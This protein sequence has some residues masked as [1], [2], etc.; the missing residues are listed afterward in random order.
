MS[1]KFEQLKFIL[2]KQILGSQ[3]KQ[4]ITVLCSFRYR[5]RQGSKAVCPTSAVIFFVIACVSVSGATIFGGL[6]D[7]GYLDICQ[8]HG[9]PK[10]NMKINK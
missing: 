1:N 3:V 10:R 6:E 9:E 7:E 8:S 2:E 5:V 4:V